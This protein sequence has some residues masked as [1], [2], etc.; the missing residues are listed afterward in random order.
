MI[1]QRGQAQRY[2]NCHRLWFVNREKFNLL[3][4]K[5][6]V[7]VGAK[8]LF[9]F[10]I[11]PVQGFVA[12]ARRTRDIWA[13]SFLLSWLAGVAMKTV[14]NGS[15]SIVFPLPADGYLDWLGGSQSGRV[16]RQ[17]EIPNRFRAEV[18]ETFE[19]KVVVKNV[20][21]AWIELAELVWTKD[22][23]PRLTDACRDRTRAIWLRQVGV[24]SKPEPFWEIAWCMHDDRSG[25]PLDRRKNWRTRI[26]G[27]EPGVKCMVIGDLQELSG[28]GPGEG[29][30]KFWS[31]LR[32]G[33]KSGI[34]SD[35]REGECLSSVAYVKRRFARYF[36]ELNAE[37]SGWK[38][39]GWNLHDQRPANGQDEVPGIPSVQTVAAAPWL[40]AILKQAKYEQLSELYDAARALVDHGE[41]TTDIRCIQDAATRRKDF[42]WLPRLDAHAFYEVALENKNLFTDYTPEK[43]RR[44][45]SA[46]QALKLGR[47]FPFYA[48]LAMDGDG[49]GRS[50]SVHRDD[51][52]PVTRSL[53]D[54]T[55][56]VIGADGKGIV[57]EHDGFL[58]YAGGDDVL[59]FL[60]VARAAACALAIRNA[61]VAAGQRH[62]VQGGWSISAGLHFVPTHRPLTRVVSETQELLKEVAKTRGGRDAIAIRL[63]KPAGVAAEWVQKWENAVDRPTLVLESLAEKL[64][65]SEKSHDSGGR[66]DNVDA[67]DRFSHGFLFKIREHL[68]LLQGLDKDVAIS[69]LT[70]DYI[71]SWGGR[72]VSVEQAKGSVEPLYEQSLQPT[73]GSSD[74]GDSQLTEDAAMLIRFLSAARRG[75]A[76]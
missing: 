67:A 30:R 60:P 28:E 20:R 61:F 9:D 75:G 16:P 36:V 71:N 15:G 72:S 39:I 58:L 51:P 24:L 70:A 19:P 27:S 25:Q 44:A 2:S 14:V 56:S 66:V 12:Q 48:V 76:S 8:R 52:G 17:G 68:K 4:S 47:P 55:R 35:L 10:T 46:L 57:Y 6:G 29:V 69:L 22:L 18:P 73:S 5:W 32:D 26:L 7:Y 11:G 1:P 34:A 23:A 38:L 31:N 74:P 49:L 3:I 62:G 64:I 65:L 43:A 21:R 63:T 37:M 13:G 33:K 41:W 50:L 53:H 59:A 45:Q 42:A 40:A 54:F